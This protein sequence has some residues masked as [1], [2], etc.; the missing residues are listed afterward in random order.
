MIL[1]SSSVTLLR[2]RCSPIV[3]RNFS[4]VSLFPEKGVI[5]PPLISG[6]LL[7]LLL[8]STIFVGFLVI[9]VLGFLRFSKASKSC[10]AGVLS[11]GSSGS[12]LLCPFVL[13]LLGVRGWEFFSTGVQS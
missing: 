12:F 2:M 6:A 13:L 1:S 11:S 7:L 9:G 10:L 4:N 3:S 8:S 5:F